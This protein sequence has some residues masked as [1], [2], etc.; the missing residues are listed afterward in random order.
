MTF[1]DIVAD[2]NWTVDLIGDLKPQNDLTWHYSWFYVN[3]WLIQQF[4][5]SKWLVM[6]LHFILIEQLTYSTIC[7]LRMLYYENL[8]HYN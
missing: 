5:I 1:Y 2:Y 4:V 8:F 6:R 7:K 3:G